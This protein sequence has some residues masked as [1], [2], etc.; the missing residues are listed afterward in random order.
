[1]NDKTNLR[2]ETVNEY[3]IVD[4]KNQ[5]IKDG[6]CSEEE[7]AKWL[8]D[9][10][11]IKHEPKPQPKI[12]GWIPCSERLPDKWEDVM[13]CYYNDREEKHLSDIACLDD[14]GC[15]Q[16]L[17]ESGG[18]FPYNFKKKITHWRPLPN[19]PEEYHG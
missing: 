12:G 7:A 10:Y 9:A 16:L 11:G 3:C 18:Y 5:I 8:E 6:F 2:I 15:W 4:E 19:L 1:M 13:I 17:R 14:N